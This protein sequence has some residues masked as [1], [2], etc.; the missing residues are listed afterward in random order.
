MGGSVS[1]VY[2]SHGQTFPD[3]VNGVSICKV[4]TD[5]ITRKA[6]IEGSHVTSRLLIEGLPCSRGTL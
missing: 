4:S 2:P 6:V 3:P 1:H 5:T